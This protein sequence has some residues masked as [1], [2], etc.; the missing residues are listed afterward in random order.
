VLG[1]SLVLAKTMKREQIQAKFKATAERARQGAAGERRAAVATLKGMLTVYP[2]LRDYA[3]LIGLTLMPG[4][5]REFPWLA[6]PAKVSVAKTR[7]TEPPG[8]AR[9]RAAVSKDGRKKQESCAREASRAEASGAWVKPPAPA[10]YEYRQ[11]YKDKCHCMRGGAWHGPYRYAKHWR[12]GKVSSEYLG[13]EI[14]S[15][16]TE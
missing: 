11:C 8:G 16:T 3:R 6:P 12:S 9:D 7:H 5:T 1:R 10:G 15:K 13:R 2:W 14:A 4:L